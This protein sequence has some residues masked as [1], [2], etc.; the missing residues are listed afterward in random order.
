M[1]G[2]TVR[3]PIVEDVKDENPVWSDPGQI[4]KYRPHVARCV[5]L[6][7]HRADMTFAVN[8]LCQ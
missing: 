4:S 7:Q 2:N 6:S 3:T 8:E 5:F 1:N